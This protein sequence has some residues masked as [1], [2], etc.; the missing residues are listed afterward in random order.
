MREHDCVYAVHRTFKGLGARDI[1]NNGLRLA[2][3]L[4]RLRLASHERT[5]GMPLPDGFLHHQA[6][7][8]AGGSNHKYGHDAVT[9]STARRPFSVRG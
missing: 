8:A 5:Y 6:A 7:D 9:S 1:T 2:G 4:T 3:K